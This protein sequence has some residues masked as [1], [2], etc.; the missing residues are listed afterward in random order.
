MKLSRAAWRN[1]KNSLK[2][3]QMQRL[4][5]KY[6][7]APAPPFS[8]NQDEVPMVAGQVERENAKLPNKCTIIRSKFK[9]RL[10]ANEGFLCA[11]KREWPGQNQNCRAE[12]A[13]M[14]PAN[15]QN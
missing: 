5:H 10:A 9:S 2:T 3:A 12:A 13:K 15:G 6:T 14:L 8:E 1:N 4:A 11:R 7:A